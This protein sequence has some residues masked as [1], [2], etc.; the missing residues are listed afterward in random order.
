MRQGVSWEHRRGLSQDVAVMY[1]GHGRG[2]D[3]SRLVAQ[4]G[5]ALSDS[6]VATVADGLRKA[7][8]NHC[9]ESSRRVLRCKA[10]GLERALKTPVKY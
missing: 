7:V 4:R 8:I 6:A 1:A 2:A 10:T 3:R 9:E 5:V